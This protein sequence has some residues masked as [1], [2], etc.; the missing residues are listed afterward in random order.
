MKPLSRAVA[1]NVRAEVARHRLPQSAIAEA[2][3]L[4]Q[5]AVSRRLTGGVPFE[6]DEVQAIAGLIG[7]PTALLLAESEP[8][9]AVSA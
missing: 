8:A 3:G 9:T 7:V 1:E 4:S 5:Q 2:L 6:L